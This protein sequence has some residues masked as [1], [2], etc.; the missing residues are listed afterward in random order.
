MLP[1]RRAWCYRCVLLILALV[2][3]LPF[4]LLCYQKDP[5][6]GHAF[7]SVSADYLVV[8]RYVLWRVAPRP[9]RAEAT[10]AERGIAA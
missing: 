1:V 6:V 5:T 7:C 2:M 8:A 3:A 9:S 10:L 4:A